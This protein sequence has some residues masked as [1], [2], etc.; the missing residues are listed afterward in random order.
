MRLGYIFGAVAI[1]LIPTR[2][3][4]SVFKR[5]ARKRQSLERRLVFE[6]LSPRIV[7]NADPYGSGVDDGPDGGSGYYSGDYGSGYDKYG[8]GY[9]SDYQEPD[10]GGSYGDGPSGSQYGDSNSGGGSS[11]SSGSGSGG[12]GSSGSGSGGGSYGGGATGASGSGGQSQNAQQATY[13]QF[14]ADQER[15]ELQPDWI[16]YDA[17]GRPVVH[18]SSVIHVGADSQFDLNTLNALANVNDTQSLITNNQTLDDGSSV[19]VVDQALVTVVNNSGNYAYTQTA[20]RNVSDP[21]DTKPRTE[22]LTPPI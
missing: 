22:S 20:S 14:Q 21:A 18:L 19:I 2:F 8:S 16:S 12:S 17:V 9:G 7:M 6:Q 3:V 13:A 4:A 10:Y 5:R 11:G 1:T 15:G